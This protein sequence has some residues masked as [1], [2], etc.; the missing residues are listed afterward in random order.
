MLHHLLSLQF[1]VSVIILLSVG[2]G[3][4]QSKMS[5]KQIL[6]LVALVALGLVV[7]FQSYSA[8]SRNRSRLEAGS[9]KSCDV[10]CA[11]LVF[12][13]VS[14]LAIGNLT[15]EEPYKHGYP[16]WCIGVC[17]QQGQGSKGSYPREKSSG[18]A[19]KQLAGN[20]PP[21]CLTSACPSGQ[22]CNP[23]GG[24]GRCIGGSPGSSKCICDGLCSGGTHDDQQQ[25]K[26][27]VIGDCSSGYC[28]E[29]SDGTCEGVSGAGGVKCGSSAN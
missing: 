10:C 11:T 26:C 20:L 4:T 12:I 16:N 25:P 24:R 3:A 28:V 9:Q 6:S 8:F 15:N 21:V 29:S 19:A 27:S 7:I 17:E 5:T 22:H 13:A 18:G 14:L 2:L 23:D 1:I